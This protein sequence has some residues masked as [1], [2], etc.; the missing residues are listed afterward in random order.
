MRFLRKILNMILAACALPFVLLIRILSPL[1]IV[2]I[3]VLD[4]SRIGHI[5]PHFDMYISRRNAGLDD[6]RNFDLCCFNKEKVANDQTK[7][8]V[9][10]A[11]PIVPFAFW[12]DKVNKLI[13]GGEKHIIPRISRR[14]C[15]VIADAPSPI[16]FTEKEHEYGENEIKRLGLPSDKPFICFHAREAAYL[17]THLPNVTWDYHSYRNADINNYVP[18]VEKLVSKGYFAIRMGRHVESK[19]KTNNPRIIDYGANG[20]TDFLDVY[21]SAHCRFFIAGSD[22]L[23]LMPTIFRR[24]V[25][26]IDFVPFSEV[27]ILLRKQLFIPKKLWSLKKNRML[28][29]DEMLHT[30]VAKYCRTEDYQR[31]GIEVI[32]NTAEEILDVSME[33]EERLNGT[34]HETEE[35]ENLQK[36]FR[37]I[38]SRANNC[39][40]FGTIG[41]KFLRQ[42]RELLYHDSIQKQHI[43]H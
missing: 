11:I 42:N 16:S 39:E 6:S 5:L 1:V 31:A 7:K 9:E 8:M 12:I 24:P 36:M 38:V 10:R 37:E 21:L 43:I 30:E 15:G 4:V 19:I 28:T 17:N 3:Y 34:W 13:P 27:R 20:G 29:F 33:M 18:A 41:T 40:F 32:N 26:W 23:A 14:D 2:R 22:G 35:D 25:I